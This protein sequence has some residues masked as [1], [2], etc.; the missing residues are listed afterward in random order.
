MSRR[1]CFKRRSAH[2]Q[3]SPRLRISRLISPARS[4][5]RVGSGNRS[6]SINRTKW[7]KRSSSPWC[8]VAVR[9]SRWSA[10]AA[11]LASLLRQPALRSLLEQGKQE[12]FIADVLAMDNDDVPT[13]RNCCRSQAIAGRTLAN[14]ARLDAGDYIE[15]STAA[16]TH[17]STGFASS[18]NGLQAE[19]AS[20]LALDR[21]SNRSAAFQNVRW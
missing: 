4:P 7:L 17:M 2:G 11:N 15:R 6:G 21:P 20:F 18:S 10:S 13:S 9:S 1:S 8:G 3:F 12:K 14:L 16:G 5:T 19:S